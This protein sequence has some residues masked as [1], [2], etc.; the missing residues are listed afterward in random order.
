ML[1]NIFFVIVAGLA[2]ERI[3]TKTVFFNNLPFFIL[4]NACYKRQTKLLLKLVY[5]HVFQRTKQLKQTKDK[6]NKL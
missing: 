2:F 6:R 1:E 5:F 3:R 4:C